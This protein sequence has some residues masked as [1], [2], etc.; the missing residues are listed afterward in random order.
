MFP[1]Q[2]LV[3]GR[4]QDQTK[5]GR[6]WY[7]WANTAPPVW[8]TQRTT[9]KTPAVPLPSWLPEIHTRQANEPLDNTRSAM[10]RDLYS[11]RE[12]LANWND[13]LRTHIASFNKE[14]RG[15]A[16]NVFA[17]PPLTSSR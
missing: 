17:L 4:P 6:P 2:P 9:L 10:V 8:A 7:N 5:L 15:G 3:G 1:S 13:K 16:T 14:I 12:E 11:N